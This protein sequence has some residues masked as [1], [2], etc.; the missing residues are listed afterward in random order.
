MSRGTHEPIKLD[1]PKTA[2]RQNSP[3]TTT[4]EEFSEFVIRRDVKDFVK[5]VKLQAIREANIQR[6]KDTLGYGVKGKFRPR[7]AHEKRL[8]KL[9]KKPEE[10]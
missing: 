5:G 2:T 4:Q 6:R 1:K 7:P 9:D 10:D 8:W 3:H